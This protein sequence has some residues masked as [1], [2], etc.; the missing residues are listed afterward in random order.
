MLTKKHFIALADAIAGL[1]FPISDRQ[2]VIEAVGNVISQYNEMFDW[3]RW[4]KA[5][6]GEYY[7]GKPRQAV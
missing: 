6:R 3:D 4:E 2:E 7:K 1:E 5:C